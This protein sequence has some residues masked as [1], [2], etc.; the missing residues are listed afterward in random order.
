[1]AHPHTVIIPP[2]IRYSLVNNPYSADTLSVS[3]STIGLYIQNVIALP[4]PSSATAK[5]S[6]MELYSEF[7]P[8][9]PLPI[10]LMRNRRTST[11]AISIN[12]LNAIETNTFFI[13]RFLS[14]YLTCKNVVDLFFK[15]GF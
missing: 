13:P 2:I 15:R 12:I 6:R 7:I 1:M 9:N 14:T 4:T 11:S 5:K 10:Y 8:L 3:P